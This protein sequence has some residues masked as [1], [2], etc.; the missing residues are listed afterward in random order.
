MEEKEAL[1]SEKSSSSTRGLRVAW[2][3]VP[4]PGPLSLP[5]P[6]ALPVW[7]KNAYAAVLGLLLL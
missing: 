3:T 2:K 6:S 5:S 1:K 7:S 4:T